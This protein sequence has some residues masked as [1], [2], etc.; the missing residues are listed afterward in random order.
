MSIIV[1]SSGTSTLPNISPSS[2]AEIRPGEA[3]TAQTIPPHSK[4]SEVTPEKKDFFEKWGVPLGGMVMT[5]VIGY[6]SAIL[7]LKDNINDNKTE[8]SVAKK[9]IDNIKEKIQRLDADVGK[10]PEMR[11]DIA[12]L[13]TK[14]DIS[15][16][17]AKKR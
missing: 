7:P 12:I 8:I 6:F 17:K 5:G 10:I 1:S 13:R 3:V 15:D 4:P 2:S 14:Q 9:D 16:G 11:T